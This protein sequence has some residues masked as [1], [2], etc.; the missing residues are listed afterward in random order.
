MTNCKEGN[1]TRPVHGRGLCGTHYNRLRRQGALGGAECSVQGCTKTS[2]TKGKCSGH[3][4]L[5]RLEGVPCDA[6][7]C[8]RDSYER[9]Y[10]SAH[11]QQVRRGKEPGEIMVKAPGE[12]SAWGVHAQGYVTSRRTVNGKRVPRFQHRV[13]ME[14]HLGRPLVKGENV[15]HKNGNRQDNRLS[16][17]ELWNTRQ[18]KGQRPEDKVEYAIEILRLYAPE[19]LNTLL[20]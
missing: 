18:P 15:H 8:D 1:C 3:Y 11:V 6:P 16:N 5:S 7:G 14:E 9:G 20:V 19:K 17:L 4:K 13:V 12:W 2:F 10:C